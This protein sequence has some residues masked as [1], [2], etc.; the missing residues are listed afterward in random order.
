MSAR[1][2]R[3][4]CTAA[5]ALL[6]STQHSTTYTPI[7][8][9]SSSRSIHAPSTSRRAAVAFA[10]EPHKTPYRAPPAPHDYYEDPEE[11]DEP[12]SVEAREDLERALHPVWEELGTQKQWEDDGREEWDK[13]EVYHNTEVHEHEDQGELRE[14]ME[15]LRSEAM[16]KLQPS[17]PESKPP[18]PSS[19]PSPTA[20]LE[21]KKPRSTQPVTQAPPKVAPLV[22][23]QTPITSTSPIRP[24]IPPPRPASR[25]QARPLLSR[26][27][28]RLSSPVRRPRSTLRTS[29]PSLSVPTDMS[30]QGH[31]KLV[32]IGVEPARVGRWNKEMAMQEQ[33]GWKIRPPS[34]EK[35]EWLAADAH[36]ER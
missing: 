31:N 12:L 30:R 18:I 32:G 5:Q 9:P 17:K 15:E 26:N 28:W 1:T 23:S 21:S 27:D 10:S 8:G 13:E 25:Q 29:P 34:G 20:A 11:Y 6:R 14:W 33:W 4:A 22:R 16:G 35:G 24:Y 36:C 7:A 2:G 19:V 3:Q